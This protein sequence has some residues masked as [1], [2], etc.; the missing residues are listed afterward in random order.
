MT[1][2]TKH[3]IL[4]PYTSFLADENAPPGVLAGGEAGTRRAA[5]L[6]DRLGEAE[7]KAAFVQRSE[8]RN[9]QDARQ[10]AP[11]ASTMGKGTPALTLRDIDRDEAV[12]VNAVQMVGEKVLYRRGNTWYSCDVAQR[13]PS[14]LAGKVQVIER[15][16]DEYFKLVRETTPENQRILASQKDK[17]EIV[18]RHG[19]AGRAAPAKVYRVK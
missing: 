12:A 14:E 19:A 15:F 5:I 3:G 9:L 6:L 10:A 2:S 11:A 8:R 13:T 17:E 18:I 7:G 4:T 1:L 16:S